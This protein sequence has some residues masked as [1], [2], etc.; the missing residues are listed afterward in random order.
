[1]AGT[2]VDDKPFI[3]C[4]DLSS[5][6]IG[7]APH[8]FQMEG[9]EDHA[10]NPIILL[11]NV[12]D[13]FKTLLENH[14]FVKHQDGWLVNTR[15]LLESFWVSLFG[16]V[17]FT[18]KRP[19]SVCKAK[20]IKFA[21]ASAELVSIVKS[22][23]L[24]KMKLILRD[25]G[26]VGDD[27][28]KEAQRNA[29]RGA[30][31]C[32]G[33]WPLLISAIR[34]RLESH[35]EDVSTFEYAWQTAQKND[36]STTGIPQHISFERLLHKVIDRRRLT[37]QMEM[38]MPVYFHL[39]PAK[40]LVG[41]SD[42]RESRLYYGSSTFGPVSIEPFEGVHV[43]AKYLLENHAEPVT[44][45]DL[46][47]HFEGRIQQLPTCS[48]RWSEEDTS[49]TETHTDDD[50]FD[51][52]PAESKPDVHTA[53]SAIDLRTKAEL[54]SLRHVTWSEVYRRLGELYSTASR[55]VP[56]VRAYC[57]DLIN[58]LIFAEPNKIAS[59]RFLNEI[60]ALL[61]VFAGVVGDQS[62]KTIWDSNGVAIHEL[63]QSLGGTS[64][65][66]KARLFDYLGCSDLAI[67]KMEASCFYSQQE[68]TKWW[69]RGL[70]CEAVD[71]VWFLYQV[72]HNQIRP[73]PDLRFTSYNQ[74]DDYLHTKGRFQR[75]LCLRDRS[76]SHH[77][78]LA[79]SAACGAVVFMGT[80]GFPNEEEAKAEA[81]NVVSSTCG[82]SP[83]EHL[84]VSDQGI[85]LTSKEVHDFLND[86]LSL[87]WP[88]RLSYLTDLD[89][90]LTFKESAGGYLC[91]Y[92]DGQLLER[93][94]PGFILHTWASGFYEYCD[95]HFPD[96]VVRI[97]SVLYWKEERVDLDIAYEDDAHERLDG[98]RESIIDTL[99]AVAFESL[100]DA[101]D[102]PSPEYVDICESLLDSAEE[103]SCDSDI[104]ECIRSVM[105][106][107]MQF[108][109]RRVITHL[110][111]E[112]CRTSTSTRGIFIRTIAQY[113]GLQ[114]YWR[115]HYT[116]RM[117]T[118]FFPGDDPAG[119]LYP[120]G[121]EV[122]TVGSLMAMWSDALSEGADD[123]HNEERTMMPQ[124]S[125][126]GLFL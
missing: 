97:C 18:K 41:R 21:P 26:V 2:E 46:C 23:S 120:S 36:L 75:V 69:W 61:S 3:L 85:P 53:R 5:L 107:A 62:L 11:S 27:L 118:G 101:I 25:T 77:W 22:Y 39:G 89:G 74:V 8:W 86:I 92:Y 48:S 57:V 63:T 71:N 31:S 6:G 52:T 73:V 28:I 29:A 125:Q 94:S 34:D 54:E 117:A 122:F 7:V 32:K 80:K 90:K 96:L 70:T 78:R 111:E 51:L 44:D 9:E 24:E 82:C 116:P 40:L 4:P 33:A 99:G 121:S 49:Q 108:A 113:L 64:L 68:S 112:K 10:G 95:T 84:S 17:E 13:H 123:S 66:R 110:F 65:K 1:M 37:P 14:Q 87:T 81:T 98:L 115:G 56:Y 72:Q 38:V 60:E 83:G 43:L 100:K 105:L 91:A 12:P 19:L 67:A 35:P 124:V 16:K 15:G 88:G 109:P 106:I 59:R 102:S 20:R 104:L 93:V 55:R 47:Q 79:Y 30:V 114:L 119:E 42:W 126:M 103:Q 50:H 76:D 45:E 58:I